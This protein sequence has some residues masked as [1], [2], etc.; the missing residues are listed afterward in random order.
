VSTR[1]REPD[2]RGF[3]ERD[4]VRVAWERFGE[5]DPAILFVPTWSIVHSRVW[6]LQVPDFARRHRVVTF[7]PRG[8]GLSDRPTEVSAY[9]E[10]EFA[11]DILDVLDA[12]GTQ[13]AVLVSLSLG[14]QR[15][16]LVAAEHPERVAGAV[17]I[18]PSLRL[19]DQHAERTEVPFDADVRIDAGWARYNRFS[20]LRDYDGFLEFFFGEAFSEPH[21]TK[22]IEDCVGW[23]LEIGPQTLIS[24]HLSATIG[25]RARTLELAARVR[26]PVL[27]IHGEA[28]RISPHRVGAALAEATGG[29]LVTIEGGGHIPLARDPVLVNLLIRDFV[30]SLAATAAAEADAEAPSARAIA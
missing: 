22:P 30:A 1:A 21:S 19:A 12:T 14:A 15:S 9:D 23:G 29:R 27:V 6:K 8:N 26:C 13:R 24:T 28:D 4:G 18:G 17:F 16:L 5:G 7:D 2:A 20:W 3:V 11:R 25:D 10:A